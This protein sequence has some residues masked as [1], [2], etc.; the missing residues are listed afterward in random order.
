MFFPFVCKTMKQYVMDSMTSENEK[1][2]IT[3]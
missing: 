3:K 1:I 2:K